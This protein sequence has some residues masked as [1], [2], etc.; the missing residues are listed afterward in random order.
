MSVLWLK[1]LQQKQHS[2]SQSDSLVMT[3]PR[4][5]T[6]W[7]SFFGTMFPAYITSAQ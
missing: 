7:C 2:A 4:K 5:T 3:L 1:Y 6:L